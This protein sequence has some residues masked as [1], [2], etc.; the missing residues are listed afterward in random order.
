MRPDDAT[1]PIDSHAIGTAQWRVW[2]AAHVWHPFT[3][4][5]AYIDEAAPIITDAAAFELIDSEGRRYLDGHSS[6]WCNVHG[7]R[8]PELDEALVTQLSRVAHTTLLG[9]S[10][11]P[12]IELAHALVK[13]AP[14]GLTRVFYSDNG[15][16]A[17][18][19]AIKL[20]YQYHLQ[21]SQGSGRRPLF[22]GLEQAY[23]GDT[24]GTVSV[25]GIDLFHSRFGG[26][27]FETAR[28]PSPADVC[29]PTDVPA[30]Q[31]PSRCLNHLAEL[32]DREA[33]RVAAV[34]IE[35]LV[36]CAAGILVHPPGFL[37]QVRELTRDRG[38]PLIVDEVAVGFGRLGRLFACELEAV[39]PDF[40]CLSKGLTGGYLPLAATLTTDQIY[41]AFLGHPADGRTFYHGHT[42]TGNPLGCAVALASL[43]RL[44]EQHVLVNAQRIEHVLAEELAPIRELAGVREVRHRGTMVGIELGIRDRT[45]W[46]RFSPQLRLGHQVCLAARRRGVIIRNVGDV[47]VLFP[48]PAMP[49]ALVRQLVQTIDQS[50]REVLAN[51]IEQ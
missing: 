14:S 20:A 26:L 50:L 2:D 25:G 37:R 29:R 36:Q 51:P 6:L 27:L 11:P 28:I 46:Q 4:M 24:V 19:V 12:S 39:S 49:E 44:E 21:K 17:V 30:D 5:S 34:V 3:A 18:E 32:L 45:G 42:Y 8:V 33:A 41:A 10:S 43:R 35:P 31:W 22:I 47:V 40:L 15:S 23:H 7:H 16:T 9:L 48:A 1:Q 13:R 38:V